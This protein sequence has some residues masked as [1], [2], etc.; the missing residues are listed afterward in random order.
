MFHHLIILADTQLVNVNRF[1]FLL[2]QILFFLGS[3]FVLI[4]AF[5]S[6]FRHEAFKKYLILF[7][8]Y[9]FAITIFTYLKAKGY[10]ALGLYP[11]LLAFGSVYLEH[12][13]QSGWQRY[14]RPVLIALPILLTLSF[15]QFILPVL[16]P[17]EIEQKAEQ[18][19]EMDLTRWEDGKV[20]L[21]P[22]DFADMIGWKE[23]A[24]IV[25]SAFANIS[26]K[27]NTIIHCDNYGQAG[28]INFYSEQKYTE[29]VSMNADYIN[30]YPL[31]EMEIKNVILVKERWDKDK[32]REREK[33]LF[34]TVSFVGE[35]KNNYAREH[36]TRVY[37]LLG[38]TQ[39][40][41]KI[42]EEEILQRKSH[43]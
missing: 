13:L 8:T 31:D 15:F 34:E 38:A 18:F 23:L 30:W 19:K 1:D 5:I 33:S 35:I 17:Q 25:D 10:Y 16:S 3:I 42:L 4:A 7:W 21:L 12:L 6:F 11:V 24:S 41:N 39:S 22:Q 29:A 26:D 40:I 32:T 27:E 9:V 43:H 36:G 20:Y 28:A 37:L 2:E 14:I